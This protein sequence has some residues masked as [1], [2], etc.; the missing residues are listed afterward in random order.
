MMPA[1]KEF[2]GAQWD[3]FKSQVEPRLSVGS[4]YKDR[5]GISL[6]LK[7]EGKERRCACPIHGGERA[8]SFAVNSDTLQWKCWGQ[9]D[10]GGG[11]IEYVQE[12]RQCTLD[13]ARDELARSVGVDLQDA[14]PETAW[15]AWCEGRQLSPDGVRRTFNLRIATFIRAPAAIFPVPGRE[16]ARVRFLERHEPKVMWAKGQAKGGDGG[17]CWYGLEQ[18]V[19][20]LHRQEDPRLYVVNGEPSVWACAQSGVPAV[21]TCCGE[22]D[23]A[24]KLPPIEALRSALPQGCTLGVIFDNDST[25]QKGGPAL[26]AALAKAG[27]DA[28]ALALPADLPDHGDVDDLHRQV[29]D[30][31]LGEALDAL[32]PFNVLALPTRTI[33]EQRTLEPGPEDDG[34][35]VIMVGD[36]QLSELVDEAWTALNL[37]NCP[38]QVF[39][40]DGVMVRLHTEEGF[41]RLE[42][43]TESWLLGRL[44]RVARWAKDCGK[45]GVRNVFPAKELPRLMLADPDRRLPMLDSIVAA[46]VFD[47]GGGLIEVAGY[48][49][50][51]RL[52]YHRPDGLTLGEVPAAP[53][54][55]DVAAARD[56]LIA[57]LLSEFPFAGPSDLAHALGGLLL[58]F[59]RRMVRGCTPLHLVEAPTPGTGKTYL[60]LIANMLIEGNSG[61][62]I[63]ITM[64]EPENQKILFAKLLR[65]PTILR[66][67]N[68]AGGID[69]PILAEVLTSEGEWECRVLGQSATVALPIRCA[70]WATANNPKLSS[71]VTRRTVRIRLN[72]KIERPECRVF[73]RPD[74]LGWVAANRGKILS[75]MFLLVRAWIAAGQPAGKATLGGFNQWSR[76]VGGILDVSG[77]PGFMQ[78]VDELYEANDEERASWA[79]FTVAWWERFGTAWVSVGDLYR[80]ADPPVTN[81]TPHPATYLDQYLGGRTEKAKQITIGIAL[82]GVRDRVFGGKRIQAQRSRTKSWEYRLTDPEDADGSAV[83]E[84]RSLL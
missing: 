15:R 38:P 52:W 36:K 67:D 53:I 19:P 83:G 43:V 69:S 46:P 28:V 7:G 2:S 48:H 26:A 20:L 68:L 61:Q 51:S 27:F 47:V 18:A 29:G 6:V 8:D 65:A 76:V 16:T 54:A 49:A 40:R 4:V 30:A 14:N 77:V 25:G 5:A 21:C 79:G 42:T 41:P 84:T 56:W 1:A 45:S 63:R 50:D 13:E 55:E 80:L 12:L 82:R 62:S 37:A 60:T 81:D 44:C 73:R 10:R 9:C 33:G 39:R 74:L 24:K 70:W 31:G 22:N 32:L 71:E 35:P 23:A 66:L 78:N 57:E 64:D 75:A 11:P 34:R 58:P 59:V 17:P 3:R 72:P